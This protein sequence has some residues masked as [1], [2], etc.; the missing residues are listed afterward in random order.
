MAIDLNERQTFLGGSNPISLSEYYKGGSYV[1]TAYTYTNYTVR[2]SGKYPGT[3]PTSG[4]IDIGDLGS[5]MKATVWS[6]GSGT[7]LATAYSSNNTTAYWSF[8]GYVDSAHRGTG[9]KIYFCFYTTGDWARYPHRTG[10]ITVGT[11]SSFSTPANSDKTYNGKL[12][13]DGGTSIKLQGWYSGPS[14]NYPNGRV[15]L[16]GI[17]ATL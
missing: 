7:P 1:P 11:A 4:A 10:S 2:L 6:N 13:Y 15:Y 9:D 8:T 12:T 5:V 17:G 14:T 3:C 16:E